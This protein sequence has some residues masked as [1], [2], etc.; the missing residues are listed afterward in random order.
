MKSL[1][2][3][4]K[5]DFTRFMRRVKGFAPQN[6][7]YVLALNILYG[8]RV[9]SLTRVYIVGSVIRKTQSVFSAVL[10]KDL[11][12]LFVKDL[13]M[14]ENWG[15]T[16]RSVFRATESTMR[17]KRGTRDILSTLSYRAHFA[18]KTF[19]HKKH[20]IATVPNLAL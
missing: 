4:V 17:T 3:N 14:K 13:D 20:Q 2:K 11:N 7:L 12:L 19:D 5:R 9:N 1:V 16:T 15:I 6:V 10:V 18:A 8:K